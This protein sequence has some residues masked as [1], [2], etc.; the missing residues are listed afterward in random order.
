MPTSRLLPCTEN[1]DGPEVSPERSVEKSSDG[2]K[3]Y[4]LASVSVLLA[5][6]GRPRRCRAGAARA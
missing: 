5:F 6:G 3:G 2:L 4:G 1:A